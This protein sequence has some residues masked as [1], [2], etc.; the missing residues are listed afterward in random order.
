V[1]GGVVWGSGRGKGP[2]GHGGEARSSKQVEKKG[3]GD[4]QQKKSQW[5]E[6]EICRKRGGTERKFGD[7]QGGEKELDRGARKTLRR[8]T[9]WGKGRKKTYIS[10]VRK[11]KVKKLNLKKEKKFR[12]LKE[13]SPK[14]RGNI[15]FEFIEKRYKWWWERKRFKMGRGKV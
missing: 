8:G 2:G 5:W 12:E 15:V 3:W 13:A 6:G 11:H 1:G 9:M 10:S 7:S 4:G 14:R